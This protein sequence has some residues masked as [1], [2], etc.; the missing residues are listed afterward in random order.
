MSRKNV[1]STHTLIYLALLLVACGVLFLLKGL[2]GP[3]GQ[4]EAAN[5]TPP[6]VKA[7]V[8]GQMAVPDTSVAADVDASVRDTLHQT[9]PSLTPD[10]DQ[11]TA[12]EAGA[13]DGY[14]DGYYD[15]SQGRE[16]NA[17]SQLAPPYTTAVA[18]DTYVTNYREGYRR[19]YDEGCHSRKTLAA[20]GR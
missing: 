13:E 3:T 8:K 2:T 16:Q 11:R 6:A 14:W 4:P 12:E 5:G 9:D 1:P 17:E 10:R 20:D 19:G 18:R 7:D 15:G